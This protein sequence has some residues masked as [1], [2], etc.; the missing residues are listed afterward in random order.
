MDSQPQDACSVNL[1]GDEPDVR[2]AAP[3]IQPASCKTAGTTNAA[4]AQDQQCAASAPVPSSVVDPE[5]AAAAAATPPFSLPDAVTIEPAESLQLQWPAMLAHPAAVLVPAAFPSAAGQLPP[6]LRAEA[7]HIRPEEPSAVRVP[8]DATADASTAGATL[9]EVTVAGPVQVPQLQ[10]PGLSAHPAALLAPADLPSL[11]D[12]LPPELRAAAA[13]G[14]HA[15]NK[16]GVPDVC[17]SQHLTGAEVDRVL[18][19]EQ[20]IWPQGADEAELGDNA[21]MAHCAS[22]QAIMSGSLQV[23]PLGCLCLYMLSHTSC[24]IAP[25]ILPCLDLFGK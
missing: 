22:Q 7:A 20:D 6:D 1:S 17:S 10:C 14:G 18:S 25:I 4:A 21:S 16:C 3:A 19:P 12:T 9:P 23:Q 13:H 24:N 5:A 2:P 15:L 8:E 11:S